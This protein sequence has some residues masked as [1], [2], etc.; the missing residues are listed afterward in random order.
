MLLFYVDECGGH[1]MNIVSDADGKARLKDGAS[2]YFV[3]SGVGVRDSSRKPLA[4][5]LFEIKKEYFGQY[6]DGPWGDTEIKGRHLFRAH[7]SVSA[8]KVLSSPAGYQALDTVAK[9][10][11]FV[12]QLGLVFDTYRP[13]TFTIVVDK[14]ALIGRDPHKTVA[15]LGAAYAYL[16]QRIALS[17]ERLYAGE[18]AI[19]IADQQTQHEQFFR[20]GQMNA[21]RDKLSTGLSTKPNFDLVIDKPLWVDTDLSS[22]DRELIQLADIVAYTT[23]E[24]MKSGCAPTHF[25]Y[26]WDQIRPTVALHWRHGRIE[27][28]GFAIYPRPQAYPTL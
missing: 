4:E 7:R 5:Q 10:R 17:L 16:H 14:A 9:V 23:T 1:T 20:S 21:A 2:R 15:P 25:A 18:S 11:G 22:W 27:R 8:G 19:L 24:C 3:L 13:I 12:K 26:L 6:V 28:G